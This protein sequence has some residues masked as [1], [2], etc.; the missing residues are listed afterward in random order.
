MPERKLCTVKEVLERTTEDL[1]VRD[2]Q[3]VEFTPD[4]REYEHYFAQVKL[5]AFEDLQLL[6][7]VPR[8]LAEE[9][10]RQA[11]Q[12][13]DE[14]AHRLA[15][16]TIAAPTHNCGCKSSHQDSQ[17]RFVSA[18]KQAQK[19]NNPALARLLSDHY[20]IKLPFH[21]PLPVLVKK[22]VAY[23]DEKRR[24]DSPLLV[25]LLMDVTISRNAVLATHRSLKSFL[26]RNIWIHRSGQLLQRGSYMRIWANKISTFVDAKDIVMPAGKAPWSI[27]L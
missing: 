25:S 14:Q 8:G 12:S 13:D 6:G 3:T 22:W 1:V 17:S 21:D 5:T 11:I 4:K 16:T 19:S 20:Q 26:A 2:G 18:Y 10:V 7:F 23:F 15:I 9:K 24:F 27:G